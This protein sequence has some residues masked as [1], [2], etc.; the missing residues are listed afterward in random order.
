MDAAGVSS[1]NGVLYRQRTGKKGSGVGVHEL[2]REIREVYQ[3]WLE[4]DLSQEDA[5]FAIGDLLEGEAGK[6]FS[7]EL[8]PHDGL[9]SIV[10]HKSASAGG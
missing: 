4:G 10:S 9:R 6:G 7:A 5:L 2:M 8:G 3:Q 1:L